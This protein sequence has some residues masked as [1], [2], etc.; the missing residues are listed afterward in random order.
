MQVKDLRV[1][2]LQWLNQ[3]VKTSN[4]QEMTQSERT[5]KSKN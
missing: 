4:D 5:S 3:Q 1:F 2:S